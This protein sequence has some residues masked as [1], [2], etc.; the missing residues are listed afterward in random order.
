[1]RNDKSYRLIRLSQLGPRN[2]GPN[3]TG[4]RRCSHGGLE[5]APPLRSRV[6]F[7]KDRPAGSVSKAG[8]TDEGGVGTRRAGTRLMRILVLGGG[9][10]GVTS[11]WYLARDGHEV[12]LVDREPGPPQT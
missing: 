6:G 12:T 5:I 7:R 8:V 1:M 9:V 4:Q 11:A 2:F 3:C 10:V